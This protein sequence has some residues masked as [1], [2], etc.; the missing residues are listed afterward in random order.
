MSD[1][2]SLYESDEWSFSFSHGAR[3]GKNA[4]KISK[5]LL[6]DQP[7]SGV[8]T[9]LSSGSPRR[10]LGLRINDTE[11]LLLPAVLSW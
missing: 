6:G 4:I 9:A 11:P 10:G 5:W 7:A 8:N 3:V 1:E 2:Q